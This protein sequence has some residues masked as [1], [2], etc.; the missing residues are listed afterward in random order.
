VYP[1]KQAA[2]RWRK[3]GVS[4]D[5]RG[6]LLGHADRAIQS[7]I[8]GHN[9][10]GLERLQKVVEAIEYPGLVLPGSA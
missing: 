2:E 10:P 1:G 6:A 7:R 5:D 4:E 3:A 9:G 8:Y